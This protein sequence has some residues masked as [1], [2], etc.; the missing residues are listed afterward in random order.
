MGWFFVIWM[1][2]SVLISLGVAQL[3]KAGMHQPV[4]SPI[5]ELRFIKGGHTFV[6]RWDLEARHAIKREIGTCA[7]S[8]DSLIDWYDA[9]QITRKMREMES[10]YV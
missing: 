9:M 3:M 1:L 2:S 10:E 7:Q 5:L 4:E 6:W 8:P